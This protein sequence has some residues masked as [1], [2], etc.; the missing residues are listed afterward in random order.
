MLTGRTLY[1]GLT[2]INRADT[3][4][5]RVTNVNMGTQCVPDLPMLTGQTLCT[6][7]TNVNRVDTMCVLDL[8][9][10]TGRTHCVY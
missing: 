1:T 6:K 10:F 7:L 9:M 5:T 4:C 3:V 8:P 2:N